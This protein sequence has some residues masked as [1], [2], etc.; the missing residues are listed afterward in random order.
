MVTDTQKK[1]RIADN[2]NGYKQVQIMRKGKRYTK[3]VHRL[4]AEC[5]LDNPEGYNEINHIDGNKANNAVS[6]LE[7][8]NH[9][10]NL[11]HSFRTG[12][13]PY[14][15]PKQQEAARRSA[16]HSREAFR[17]GWE[18]WAQTDRAKETW[19]NNIAK[20]DRWGTRNE[21]AEVKAERRRE[22][23]RLYYQE[24]KEERSRKAHERY[25]EKKAREI[26]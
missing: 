6:N 19:L 7:W 18:R 14:T 1:A 10:Q 2:G 4:V 20:A 9:S 15:T 8:C 13:R 17:K 21:P 5:F 24:H 16:E 23:K 26:A 25:L 12:L 3:Y 22:K 11:I